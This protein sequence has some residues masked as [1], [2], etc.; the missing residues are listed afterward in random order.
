[1]PA[2]SSSPIH[3][4]LDRLA[5]AVDANRLAGAG[6]LTALAVACSLPSFA[7][8]FLSDVA[9]GGSSCGQGFR[10]SCRC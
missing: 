4:V 10:Q 7:V 6:L 8:V 5:C 3:P 9:T 2:P 1:M